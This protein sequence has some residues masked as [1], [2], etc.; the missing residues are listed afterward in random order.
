M[1]GERSKVADK[2][3][4][5]GNQLFDFSYLRYIL[6]KTPAPTP[7]IPGGKSVVN[8]AIASIQ[9]SRIV[10]RAVPLM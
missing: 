4:V 8:N 2:K 6:P 3:L 5:M 7:L 9:A 10:I 1:F